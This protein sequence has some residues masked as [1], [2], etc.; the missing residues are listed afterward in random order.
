M[1]SQVVKEFGPS[2]DNNIDASYIDAFAS[3]NDKYESFEHCKQVIGKRLFGDSNGVN[4]QTSNKRNNYLLQ[5]VHPQ[6]N[7]I[8]QPYQTD[9]KEETHQE[10][11]SRAPLD[12]YQGF[13]ILKPE[14]IKQEIPSK[15]QYKTLAI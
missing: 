1:K 8:P 6:I 14:N 7:I 13:N 9:Y 11:I 10:I 2:E 3:T 5:Y 4:H 12:N 15:V